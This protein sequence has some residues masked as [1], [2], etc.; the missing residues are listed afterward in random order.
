MASSD[1]QV[2]QIFMIV[3]SILT[4]ILAVT[5][6][7]FYQSYKE[8]DERARKDGQDLQKAREDIRTAQTELNDLKQMVGLKP[9]LQAPAVKEQFDKDMVAFA[10]NFPEEKRHYRDALEFLFTT[11][12]DTNKHLA[13]VQV[14]LEELK[15]GFRVR[16]EIKQKQIDEHA[17]AAQAAADDLAEERAKF[18]TSLDTINAEKDD[19]AKKLQTQQ[20][21]MDTAKEEH[22]KTQKQLNTDL[23]NAQANLRDLEE[24]YREETR[25][26]FEV[27]D[28]EVVK[29]NQANGTVWINLGSADELR[30]LV[31]F[32]VYTSQENDVARNE[33]KGSIEVTQV[34]DAHL[35]EARIL[36]DQLTNPIVQGD[37]IFTPA[38][39]PGRVE[40]FALVGLFDINDDD[41]S[42]RQLIRDL[43][44]RSGAVIDAELD[45]SGQKTGQM[46]INTR[47]LVRGDEPT[48][49]GL[50]AYN[51]MIT[52]A[53]NLGIEQLTVAKFLDHVGYAANN[54][55]VLNYREGQPADFKAPPRAG[56]TPKATGNVSPLF[57]PRQPPRVQRNPAYQP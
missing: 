56:G 30:R 2:I 36:D 4:L 42:D 32:S 57:R 20:Q 47:F 10:A 54:N 51:E 3:F 13:D 45:D 17:K 24:K 14:Q 38:W 25:Q 41:K 34:L 9:E 50:A 16:E 11:L 55:S 46:S 28:G 1:N 44:L 31:T 33:R 15:E 26:T 35:A 22:E 37:K 12:S 53:R 8:A 49:E 40:R 48:G 52:E 23:A 27:A 7:L 18:K 6:F 43:V 29:V 5:T 39:H 19:L 21:Q